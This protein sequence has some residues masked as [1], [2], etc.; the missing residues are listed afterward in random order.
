MSRSRFMLQGRQDRLLDELIEELQ[1]F[2]AVFEDR[3]NNIFQKLLG[4]PHGRNILRL[5]EVA[6]FLEKLKLKP[7]ILREQPNKGRT[8]IEKFVDY[9]DVS[10]AV[11]LL[12]ADDRGGT[13]D[14]PFDEQQPRGR[15]NVILELGFFLGS[16][17][18]ARVCALYEDGVEIPSGYEGVA[19]VSLDNGGAWRMSLARE[20]KEAGLPVDMNDAI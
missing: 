11:V 15:Q 14:A 19:F 9:S 2:P 4:Q 6:R 18:R 5:E 7:I 10:F 1:I 17:G 3:A 13:F 16:L 12:T 8:I 20:I